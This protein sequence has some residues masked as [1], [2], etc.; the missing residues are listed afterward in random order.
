MNEDRTIHTEKG[1]PIPYFYGN[2]NDYLDRTVLIFGASKSGKTTIIESILYAIKDYVPNYLVIVP[3]TSEKAY[4]K[5]LP[6]RCIKE[7]LT[8]DMLKKIWARQVNIT[9]VYNI[10]NDLDV[11]ASL[12]SKKPNAEVLIM[13]KAVCMRAGQAI[14][15]INSYDTSQM[16]FAQKKSQTSHIE[17]LKVS[18]IKLLYKKSIRD[19]RSKL[20]HMD[21]SDKETIA[22]KYLDV[23]P[24]IMLII[25]DCSTQ[26]GLW[27]KMFKDEAN[28]VK[29]IF[30]RGRHNYISLIFAAHD[31]KIIDTSM[32]K[33][34][35]LTIYC[36]SKALMASL[37]KTGNGFTPQDKKLAQNMANVL[38]KDES[39]GA[40][41]YKKLCYVNNHRTPW[42]YHIADL[43]PEFNLGCEPLRDLVKKMP[44]VADNLASNPFLTKLIQ[45]D[46]KPKNKR[47]PRYARSNRSN[48]GRR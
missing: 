22:L 7:D 19:M 3:P 27:M 8:K 44:K 21:L 13:I 18:K 28:P 33:N 16:N 4:K 9:Q 11:L 10:A 6:A 20:E 2:L 30:F 26:F 14:D 35:R 31:D 48:R 46:T 47:T 45:S 34:A 43:Y 36:D 37:G 24:R 39:N 40:K 38:F 32:R 23:N 5:K 15:T 25:D 41:T 17:N 12:F 42:Q 29:D 1:E